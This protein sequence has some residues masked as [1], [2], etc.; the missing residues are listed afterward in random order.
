MSKRL[1]NLM[2]VREL[3]AGNGTRCALMS[4]VTDHKHYCKK[5]VAATAPNWKSQVRQLKN[6][7]DRNV[8]NGDIGVVDRVEP[9]RGTLSVA[10]PERADLVEYERA[11]LEQLVHAYAVSIHKSQ[12][13]EYP[14][15]VILVAT[16]HF[17]MLQ[18][19]LI[20]TAVT[21]G[22]RLVVLVGSRKA[23]NLAVTN[24]TARRRWTW[25]AER[26]RA[27]GEA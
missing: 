3:G 24:A 6:E 7:Y 10:L 23:V 20:Y 1:E 27:A 22:K 17:V 8:F 12:G 13:S 15:V 21:R 4:D 9:E 16:Q 26:I 2:F 11:D 18:R 19:S 5:S 14:A 25:L